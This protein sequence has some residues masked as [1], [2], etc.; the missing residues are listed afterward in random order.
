MQHV[1]V[2]VVV[3]VVPLPPHITPPWLQ[4]YASFITDVI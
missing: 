1:V 2:V 3:V 4:H